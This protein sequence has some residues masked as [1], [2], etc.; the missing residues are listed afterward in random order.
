ML[1]ERYVYEVKVGIRKHD[2]VVARSRRAG[3]ALDR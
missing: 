2:M 1:V 3:Q